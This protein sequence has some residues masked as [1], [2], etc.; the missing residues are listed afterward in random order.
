MVFAAAGYIV[1]EAYIARHSRT[2]AV[3]TLQERP[4]WPVN[5]SEGLWAVAFER[6]LGPLCN[7]SC[8]DREL[9]EEL[10]SRRHKA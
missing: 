3:D 5:C 1:E 10:Q 2:Q 9:E 4:G 7:Y 6:A 8:K